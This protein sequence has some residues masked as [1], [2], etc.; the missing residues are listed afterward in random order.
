MS[1][2]Q[3]PQREDEL[4]RQRGYGERPDQKFKPYAA[5]Q[6]EPGFR[7]TE[8]EG[9]PAPDSGAFRDDGD[10]PPKKTVEDTLDRDRGLVTDPEDERTANKPDTF[11]ADKGEMTTE[12]SGDDPDPK[13]ANEGH[14][15]LEDAYSA[16]DPGVTPKD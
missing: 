7:K 12:R 13:G 16:T 5:R 15:R 8:A 3:D 14:K 9:K 2:D 1:Q 6:R 11:E 4:S 10:L